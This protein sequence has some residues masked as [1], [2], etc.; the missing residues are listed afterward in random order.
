M[1]PTYINIAGLP[2]FKLASRTTQEYSGPCPFCGGDHRSD[3]FR[4]WVNDKRYWCRQCQRS[5]WL[6]ELSGTAKQSST[7]PVTRRS[8]ERSKPVTGDPSAIVAYRQLYGAVALWAHSNLLDDC[9]PEPLE[10]VRKRGFDDTTIHTNLI[11]Y[12]LQD[13]EALPYYLQR[14]HPELLAYAEGA[15]VLTDYNG[16]LLTHQS[17]RN[18]LVLPYI[19]HGEAVDLRTRSFQNKTYRSLSGSYE[20]RGA[21]F[22]FGWDA[23]DNA[24]TLILTEGEFKALAV[25][26]AARAGRLSVSAL[27][28][29]GL[30]YLHD[31]WGEQLVARGVQTVILAYDSQ[32]RTARNDMLQ[33]TP[34]E[35]WSL[36]HGET[37]AA[38]GISVRVLRL[39]LEPGTTK[40]DLDSFI[41]N[42]GPAR[43]QHLI[44]IAPDLHTYRCSLPRDMLAQAKISP[45]CTYPSRRARPQRLADTDIAPIS[46]PSVIDLDSARSEITQL[47]QAHASTGKGILVLAHPPGT[48]KGHNTAAGLKAYL[49]QHPSP[50]Q[51]VWTA[52]R[53]EQINDQ[54]G[55]DLIPLHGRNMGNCHKIGEAQALAARGYSVHSALCQRRCPH[56]AHCTYLRQF[57]QEGD[58]F[59][60]QP[61]LQA[62]RWW[63]DAGVIVLDEF[64]PARLTRIV[65]LTS[66]HLAHIAR[67]TNDPYS[68]TVLRWL[69]ALLGSCTN[70]SI[71]GVLLLSEL[72]AIA[73]ADGLDLEKTL[74]A[75]LAALPTDEEANML[76]GLPNG[77]TISHYEALAPNYLGVILRQLDRE[78]TRYRSG[79]PFTSRIELADGQLQ[80]F[81]RMEHLIAQ[82][83]NADQPKLILDATANIKL[84][85]SIFP[86]TPLQVEQPMIINNATVRQ[87]ISRDWAKTTLRGQRREAWYDAVATQIRPKR[88]TLVVCTLACTDNLRRALA[89]RGHRDVTVTHYGAL[90][91]SNNYKGH[92][93]I[94]AQV[95]HPNLNAI[96][97]E[98]R[99]LFADDPTPLDEQII[100]TDRTLRDASGASWVIQVPVF[101]DER[102]TALLE[103]QR[104]SELVQAALRG[105]PFDHADVQITLLFGLPLDQLPP[106]I[107]EE[108]VASP[109]SNAGRFATARAVLAEAAQ[110]MLDNGQ[111]IIDV[112]DLAGATEL[113]VV[114]VRKHMAAI[115]GRLKL[116]LVKRRRMVTLPQGGTR[117]YVRTVLL[118]AGRIVQPQVQKKSIIQE[119]VCCSDGTD[120]ADNRGSI[121]RVI[122][123]CQMPRP[124]PHLQQVAA[125]R[126]RIRALRRQESSE[127]PT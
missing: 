95:Y 44:D 52:L 104:E 124:M 88:P 78:Y 33:L 112:D 127:P 31:S 108:E 29:P 26:Q 64:D 3:R 100:T 83:A 109:Q 74:Q 84:L 91:G 87:I 59:A 45:P 43:L 117:V 106:T 65:T 68:I 75:A 67:Q 14:N 71:N 35:I 5:G 11:G 110:R 85:R 36:R 72:R 19:A 98:G 122:R 126:Q 116:R 77:A 94:L 60:P 56:I 23:I 123:A 20:S 51:I 39:P 76:P 8:R 17:L 90:R 55:L 89:I 16:Q 66:A 48:G 32:P 40:A 41:L 61:L 93:V 25:I 86:Q 9:N 7:T 102:L 111:R 82:L 81:L 42:Y 69:T 2:T 24:D 58:L 18:A 34:E 92:D 57:G 80:L 1:P 37:L 15:G 103:Q 50:G 118:R 70:R 47:A 63:K 107:V 21:I 4:V 22:P 120:Q 125:R 73:I 28:H 115:A 62:T 53:K 101:V 97:R 105:R 27:A 46:S 99:A 96:I 114:T 12:A 54:Q 10:Y 38:T 30:S 121:T 79:V 49:Q 6:D 13:A 113:S 119:P